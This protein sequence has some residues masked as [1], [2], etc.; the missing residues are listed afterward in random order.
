MDAKDQI[1][2]TPPS[3]VHLCHRCGWPFPNPHPSA[4]HRRAHKKICGT[5]DGYTSLI[6]SEVGSD[7]DKEK[8]PSPKIVEKV[9]DGGG[10]RV[11]FSRSEDEVFSDAVTEFPDSGPVSKTLDRDLFFSFKDAENDGANEFLNDPIEISK[12]DA[13]VEGSEKID[14]HVEKSEETEIATVGD[15]SESNHELTDT[16]LVKDGVMGHAPEPGHISHSQETKSINVVEAEEEKGQE[17]QISESST[18]EAIDSELTET[19]PEV[20][21]IVSGDHGNVKQEI[22]SDCVHVS[23]VNDYRTVEETNIEKFGLEY[24]VSSE[25][26]KESETDRLDEVAE[27]IMDKK[28]ESDHKQDPEVAKEPASVQNVSVLI[29]KEDSGAPNVQIQEVFDEPVAVITE[30]RD[31]EAHKL[32]KSS[33]Q[34]IQEVVKEPDTVLTKKEDLAGPHLEKELKEHTH[35]V[36]E[37]SVSVLTEKQDLGVPDLEKNSKEQIQ[38]VVK[39]PDTILTEKEDLGGPHLEEQS[40]KHNHGVVEKPD[41]VLTETQ[42]MGPPEPEKCSKEHVKEPDLVLTKKEDLGALKS[43]TCSKDKVIEQYVDD[44]SSVVADVSIDNSVVNGKNA[45]DVVHVPI[46][47][48]KIKNQDSGA[49]LSAVSSGRSSLEGNWGSVSVLS[50]ASIDAGSLQSTE[51]SKVNFGKSN[52]ATSDVYEP[53]SFMT[54]VETESKDKKPESSEVLDSQK[55][56]NS[57]VSQAGWFP[58][59]TKVNNESEGRKRNEEAIAKVTNWSTGKQSIPLKNLLG[60][61]K[62]PGGVQPDPMVKKDEAVV[63]PA[64]N[65]DVSSPPKL[66]DESKKGKKK[67]KGLSSWVP[68]VCCSSLNVVN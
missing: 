21:A 45:S 28:S 36:F 40:N 48:A 3:G 46:E 6:G 31:L 43:E 50:T 32:E 44:N 35:K 13:S 34:Q 27:E 23:E 63:N 37:N 19:T 64:V 16:G 54:L 17:S 59:L 58:T 8:T 65:N 49:A 4:K 61:A 1:T 11:S 41:P 56:P 24:E 10:M 2:Q 30:K 67:V 26:V 68:F 57:E 20:S 62:S 7:D 66:I 55:Q 42:Y 47:E 60:E 9:G 52:A 29:E 22:K 14:T 39:Q 51:K 33:I 12:V 15:S 53:P 18:K 25:V 38:E 5:I